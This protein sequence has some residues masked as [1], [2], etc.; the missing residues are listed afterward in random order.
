M[1][2]GENSSNSSST[3]RDPKRRRVDDA[4]A[5]EGA[6]GPNGG[7]ADAYPPWHDASQNHH[8]A[9]S[10]AAAPVPAHPFA[11][12][13]HV[14]AYAAS[15]A[16][17]NHSNHHPLPPPPQGLSEGSHWQHADPATYPELAQYSHQPY[18][19]QQ[20]TSAAANA[21]PWPA[22][23]DSQTRADLTSA[24]TT[25]L[26]R[27]E[28]STS[29]TMPYFPSSTAGTAAAISEALDASTLNYSEAGNAAQY[30]AYGPLARPFS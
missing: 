8:A 3:A 7:A 19:Y 17:Y 23:S 1:S 22:T 20:Q 2:E 24:P 18:F 27:G 26:S 4:A 21:G 6:A 13:Q 5:A 30:Q 25:T 10:S 9:S 29:T 14:S 11:P 16:E 15:G 12:A 28:S